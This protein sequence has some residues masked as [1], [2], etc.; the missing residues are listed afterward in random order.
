MA[1]GPEANP[2]TSS[3][4]CAGLVFIDMT[5]C[6]TSPEAQAQIKTKLL[7]QKEEEGK[8]LIFSQ[9]I[10]LFWLMVALSLLLV[11]EEESIKSALLTAACTW[12]SV[13]QA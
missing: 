5:V 4:P 11:K 12:V 8:N 1:A 7:G 6:Q 9:I 10:S 2:F 3:C 13:R